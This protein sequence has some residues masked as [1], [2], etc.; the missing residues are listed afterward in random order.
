MSPDSLA[1]PK[2]SAADDGRDSRDGSA[3]GIHAGMIR[4]P[5]VF[6]KFFYKKT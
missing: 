2:D 5:A 4:T 3:I 6:V 1:P